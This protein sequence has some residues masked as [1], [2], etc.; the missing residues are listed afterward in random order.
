MKLGGKERNFRYTVNSI[1]QLIKMT[2]KTPSEVLSN[3]DATNFDDNV[4]LI[5]CALL[6]ENPKLTPDIVGEWLEEDDGS[7]TQAVTE[8][9]NA[10]ISSFNKQFKVDIK[11]DEEEKN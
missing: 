1:R 8:A 11:G 2:G 4:K 5:C 7:Y 3:F 6:W 10:L 9:V